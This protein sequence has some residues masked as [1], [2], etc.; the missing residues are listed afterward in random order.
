M[1]EEL[2]MADAS[3]RLCDFGSLNET[4][5]LLSFTEESKTWSTDGINCL[6]I[7]S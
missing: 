1:T 2:T 6:I 4:D 5:M 7:L 3:S